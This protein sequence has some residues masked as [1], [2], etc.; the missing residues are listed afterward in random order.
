MDIALV[1]TVDILNDTS[2]F[3][4]SSF[5]TIPDTQNSRDEM[6]IEST[7]VPF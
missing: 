5:D 7:L 6:A 2:H 4:K 3:L 1:S